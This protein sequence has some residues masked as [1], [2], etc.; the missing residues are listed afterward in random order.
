LSTASASGSSD[1]S[2][3]SSSDSS[4]SSD[5]SSDSSSDASISSYDA[6]E[7]LRIVPQDLSQ[8]LHTK[9]DETLE[10]DFIPLLIAWA[11]AK[12]DPFNV[13][14]G[15]YAAVTNIWS[16]IF[17]RIVLNGDNITMLANVV[18]FDQIIEIN[19]LIL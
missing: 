7:G 14:N 18:S 8:L 3:N 6:L 1:D 16:Q 15:L 2:P 12:E 4:G 11:G 13:Q 17:P 9:L 19:H 5:D 10:R